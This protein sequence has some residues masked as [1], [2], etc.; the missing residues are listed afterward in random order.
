MAKSDQTLPFPIFLNLNE[1]L[2]VIVGVGTVGQRK[3]AGLLQTGARVRLVDPCLAGQ[4]PDTAQIEYRSREFRSGDLA[5]ASLA[6]AC[7]SSGEVNRQVA[8]EARLARIFCC[9]A[10]QS[11]PGDFTLPA[12]LR[13]GPLQL[14]VTTGGRSPFMAA[15]VRDQLSANVPDSWGVA[16][17]ILAAIRQKW[18]TDKLETKYNQQVLRSFWLDELVPAIERGNLSALDALLRKHFGEAFS[19]AS[20]GFP[21]PE[22][23]P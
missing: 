10:D 9:V 2:V 18:L 14:A 19:L 6:F 3:L 23:K 16:V 20:L 11:D 7:T 4:T 8:S 21:G 5:D 17:E 1:R 12:G 13:R 15:L 22:G